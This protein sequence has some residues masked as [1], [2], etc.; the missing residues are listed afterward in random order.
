[1]EGGFSRDRLSRKRSYSFSLVREESAPHPTK[2]FII[3]GSRKFAAN[4]YGVAVT[5]AVLSTQ[6]SLA[7]CVGV[8]FNIRWLGSAPC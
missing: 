1:M 2:V 7:L 5:C 4:Q 3:A 6:S 8:A